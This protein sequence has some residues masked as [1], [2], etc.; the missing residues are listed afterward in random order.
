MHAST[1]VRGPVGSRIRLALVL[2]FGA[3]FGAPALTLAQTAETAEPA[4]GTHTLSPVEVLGTTPSYAAPATVGGKEARALKDIPQSVSVLTQR[5]IQEQNLVTVADA[6]NQIPGVTVISN[7]TTQ[8]QYRARG[9]AMGVMNDGIPTF[10]ALS[11]YEQLDLSLMER[12]EVLRGPAGLYQGSGDPGGV[13]NLVRKRGTDTPMLAASL[14]LGSWQNARAVVDAGGPL[15]DTKTVRGRAVVA[16]LDRAYFYD[17]TDTR[18]YTGYGALDWDVL[19]TTTVS[20]AATYQDDTTHAPYM[21]LP[22]WANGELTHADRSTNPYP[23]WTRYLWDTQDY[24]AEVEHRLSAQWKLRVRTNRRDQGFYFKD[25]YPTTGIQ[26]DGTLTYARRVYDY[27]YHRTAADV[28]LSG[29]FDAWGLKHEVIVGYNYDRFASDNVGANNVPAVTG[30]PFGRPDLVPEFDLPYNRQGSS[31]TAQSGV[32]GSLRLGLT[33]ALSAV[34]G[35]RM[36]DYRAKSKSTA[37]TA[38]DTTPWTYGAKADDEVTPYGA[39]MYALSERASMYASY[40][41]IFIPTSSLKVGD[42]PLDPRRGQQMEAG[43][44]AEFLDGALL[45]SLSV[46]KLQDRDRAFAD[47]NNLGYYLNA[48]KVESKG[49]EV[50]VVGSPAPGW[51]LQA[52]YTRLDTRY[53]KDK[54][55]EGLVF[56]T[57]EPRHSLK[58]W[59]TRRFDDGMLRGWTLGVGTVIASSSSA[60]TGASAVR[61]QGGYSVWNAYASYLITPQAS[62]ALNVNNVFDTVY[63]TRLGGLNTYNTYGDPRNISLTLRLAY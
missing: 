33:Q 55:N 2:A 12:V 3:G 27:T 61:H 56:D 40:A 50:E 34:A 53:V 25:G 43:A 45:G 37:I 31:Q 15:N 11:G 1:L 21:G 44:K 47:P 35:A 10:S 51:Q 19:P 30:V 46:F 5:R 63:Y 6:L 28:Y 9:Y 17:R 58:F 16:V 13:V 4:A 14:S 36:S 57:W 26:T 23:F 8:S 39:L 41:D 29:S 60:G 24:L 42:I 48:G 62:V 20:L 32:Y 18:K 59:G 38:F 52:G 22:A 54:N 49:W 7:D